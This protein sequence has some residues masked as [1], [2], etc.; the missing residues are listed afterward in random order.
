MELKKLDVLV[1]GECHEVFHFIKEFQEH[2]QKCTK[3]SILKDSIQ[4]VSKSQVWAFMLW[5]N[6]K[7][8]NACEEET[9]PS[10]WNVYQ[11]WC[12]L[13]QT[14][15][16]SWVAAGKSL[17][18]IHMLNMSV[19]QSTSKVFKNLYIFVVS[20]LFFKRKRLELPSSIVQGHIDFM[21]V[22]NEVMEKTYG[23]VHLGD[24]RIVLHT[25]IFMVFYI[26]VFI[27]TA[28]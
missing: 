7:F 28:G 11:L 6:A 9:P 26:F 3:E 18:A 25:H 17:Q 5:K 21:H 24:S 1:C 15:K 2:R 22:V 10:S 12:N 16:D 19:H 13:D 20:C 23:N 4:D 14:Q 8:K 27:K